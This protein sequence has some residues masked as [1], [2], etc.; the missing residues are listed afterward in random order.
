VGAVALG[1]VGFRGVAARGGAP[2]RIDRLGGDFNLGSVF[3]YE[4]EKLA[5]NL[6]A[7][8]RGLLNSVWQKKHPDGDR[9]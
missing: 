1:E 3:P 5:D 2:W 7:E 6:G 9:G 8:T 4:L